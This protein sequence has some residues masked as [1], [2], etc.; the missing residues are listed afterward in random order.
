MKNKSALVTLFILFLTINI[1]AAPQSIHLLQT[2][3]SAQNLAIRNQGDSLQL[4]LI[5]LSQALQLSPTWNPLARTLQLQDSISG[6]NLLWFEGNPWLRWGDSTNRMV[7]SQMVR[8][9]GTLWASLQGTIQALEILSSR[10]FRWVPDSLILAELPPASDIISFRLER[11]ANGDVFEIRLAR[12]IPYETFFH[13]PHFIL[14]LQKAVL[15]SAAWVNPPTGSLV[16]RIVP[17]QEPATAQITFQVN[18][19]CEGVEVLERDEGRTLQIIFRNRVQNNEPAPTPEPQPKKVIRNIII[20]PGHGGKDPGAVGSRHKEK[21]I[22]LA[23]G[24]RLRDKLR[25]AGLRVRMTREDDSFV[26]L[27]ERPAMASRW[28]GD[29][30][31]SLHCNAIDG[32]AARK[33]RTEGFKIFILREAESEEDKAI[34]RRE[35]KAIELSQGSRAR[36]TEISPVEWILMENQLNQYS[37]KSERLAS[38]M[39]DAMQ[40]GSISKMGTGAGQAGFLVLVGAYMPAVLVELGFITHPEDEAFMGSARGQEELAENLARAVLAYKNSVEK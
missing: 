31:I 33:R 21:D 32:N 25:Q 18:D 2:G 5:A 35:N 13:R 7:N 23:V 19:R 16:R 39:V 37:R 27:Q 20:D 11:R 40:G 12:R 4:D 28:E 10:K 1:F 38:Y 29:M 26:D 8:A 30:F 36:K 6:K 34:A 9:N 14:R 15:D 22:V 24:K 17:V 3:R